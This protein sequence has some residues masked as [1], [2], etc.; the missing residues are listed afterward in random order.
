MV[1]AIILA[2]GQGTR[3]QKRKQFELLNGIE[4]WKHVYQKALK[5]VEKDKIVVVGVDV[6]GGKTRSE[7]VKMGLN[8][9]SQK[10]DRVIILEAARPLVTVE[11]IE[12][13]INTND[14]SITFALPLVNTI[15]GR[16]GTYFNR[17]D[18]YDLLTPQA[19]DYKLLKNAYDTD[20][21]RDTTDETVVMYREY[22]IKPRFILE[23]ENLIKVTYKRDMEIV[24]QML[25]NG[26]KVQ[27]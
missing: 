11:Q 15:I 5:V 14:A 25:E 8:F 18:F 6:E 26:G 20:K 12:K 27:L 4:M 7:S 2:G 9:L 10:C 3:Y 1:G 19:F 24:K 17:N 13:L 22:G 16:D 21:Y 23:G